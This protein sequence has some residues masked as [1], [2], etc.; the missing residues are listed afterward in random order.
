MLSQQVAT[1]ARALSVLRPL[2]APRPA[3]PATAVRDAVG[4][5]PAHLHRELELTLIER[6]RAVY[7][8]RPAERALGATQFVAVAPG[9]VHRIRGAD[10]G[11]P[12]GDADSPVRAVTLWID[13]AF[14]CEVVTRGAAPADAPCP[15][16]RGDAFSDPV[17]AG[18]VC[19][20]HA[21][22]AAEAGAGAQQ[23]GVA[24]VLGRLATAH[25]PARDAVAPPRHPAVARARRFLDEHWDR[26]VA[27]EE[28]AAVARLSRFH[29]VR[30]FSREVGLP[31]HAYQMQVRLSHARAALA[32]GVAISRVA[33]DAGFAD[34]S[35][36]TRTFKRAFGA[37][38]GQFARGARP[39][40]VRAA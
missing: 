27:L 26:G 11:A 10:R 3:P 32:R 15:A 19:E 37:T 20:A 38:P 39:A 22:L 1:G 18:L 16:F 36:L 31:P 29:L 40:A 14:V 25:R 21:L 2:S 8:A 5:A 4:D 9:Q 13:A 28:L 34:Q 23:D 17:L 35:H 12:S 33:Y 6:G 7:S 30:A 24:R